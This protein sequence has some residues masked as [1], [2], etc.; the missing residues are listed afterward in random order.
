MSLPIKPDDFGTILADLKDRVIF[1]E[2]TPGVSSSGKVGE[3][4]EVS[5]VTVAEDAAVEFAEECDPHGFFTDSAPTRLTVPT[6]RGGM[7]VFSFPTTDA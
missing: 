1:L 4:V 5:G 2:R 7:Y 3:S 6:G